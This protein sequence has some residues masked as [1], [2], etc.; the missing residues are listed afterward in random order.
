MWGMPAAPIYP[1]PRFGDAVEDVVASV[2][3]R[4]A[5]R[6]GVPAGVLAAGLIITA[7]LTTVAAPGQSVNG[8]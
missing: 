7:L 3:R 2:R 6:A 8:G 5:L 1:L 4:A